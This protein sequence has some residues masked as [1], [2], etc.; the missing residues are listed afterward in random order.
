MSLPAEDFVPRTTFRDLIGDE[1]EGDRPSSSSS[2]YSNESSAQGNYTLK[3]REDSEGSSETVNASSTSSKS[4][5]LSRISSK[6]SF[7]PD[8]NSVNEHVLSPTSIGGS[9]V[10]AQQGNLF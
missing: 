7:C 10:N 4:L 2:K 1:E 5:P 9:H 6:H 3:A 8:Y